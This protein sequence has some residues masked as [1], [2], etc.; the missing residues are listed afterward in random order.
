MDAD[1]HERQCVRQ[2]QC[3]LQDAL[4]RN[5]VGDVD[6]LRLRRDS[7][8]HSVTRA[9]EVV[10][11]AEVGQEGDEARHAAAESTS[12]RTSCEGASATTS[13]PR[14]RAAVV[15]CGPIEIAGPRPPALA[16]ARAADADA[17]RTRSAAGSLSTASSIVR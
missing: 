16:Y 12:P 13:T 5:P 6:D 4:C 14:S 2:S 9:D 15:V 1:R 11:E 7:L 8:H 3:T 17:R 10:L